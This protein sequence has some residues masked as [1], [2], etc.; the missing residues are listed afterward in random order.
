MKIKFT[1][2][3]LALIM[4]LSLFPAAYAAD[5]EPF[6]DVEEKH[7]YYDGVLYVYENGMMNGVG[8]D[9]FDP[10]GTT[11]R[12]MIV[13]VLHRLEGEPAP[14]KANSFE[15]VVSGSWYAK[16]VAWAAGEGI[17]N[18]YTAASFGP[19]DP[20]TREQ[21]AAILYR[22]A[23]AKGYDTEAG[24]D[25]SGYEDYSKIS[26]YAVEAL[27]WANEY[28]LIGGVT[29][30]TLCPRDGAT[31]AQTAVILSRFCSAF[32]A[33]EPEPDTPDTPDTPT[34]PDV[35]AKPDTPVVP[36]TPTE[37]E[38]PSYEGIPAAD[39]DPASPNL[40]LLSAAKNAEGLV[41]LTLELRGTVKLCGFDLKLL[42]DTGCYILQSL[43]TDCG[44]SIVASQSEGCVSFNYSAANNIIKNKTVLKAVFAPAEGASG[45]GVFHMETVEVIWTDAANDYDILPAEHTLTYCTAE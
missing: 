11:S 38:K 40:F 7:W 32:G 18:G 2:A 25:I 19:N 43:D 14:A 31:R 5:A 44:M 33:E 12:A 41:E 37:P 22:Y 26:P 20:I 13:T 24:A 29:A 21:M 3:L 30:T 6:G 9:K 15:D 4:L 36:D 16:A 1:A 34:V 45:D 27:A 17:V 10:Q 28:G 35:P 8:T 42:Y 23:K 39:A